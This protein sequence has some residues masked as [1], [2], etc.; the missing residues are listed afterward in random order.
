MPDKVAIAASNDLNPLVGFLTSELFFEKANNDG[1]FLDF[2]AL[3][4]L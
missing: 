1:L 4:K 3:Q 2:R